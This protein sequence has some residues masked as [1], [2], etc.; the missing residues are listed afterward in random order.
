MID[1]DE[2]FRGTMVLFALKRE[3]SPF[4]RS[5]RDDR[6]IYVGITGI[7][8]DR[9]RAHVESLF[10]KRIRP[11]V[12]VMA[13]YAGALRPGLGVG[14]V[15]VATEVVDA[16]GTSWPT[17]WPMHPARERRKTV[18]F[19]SQK[20][21]GATSQK[22]DLGRQFQADA[23]DME[24][25]AVAEACRQRGIPFGCVRAISDDVQTSLSPRLERMLSAG[26]ISAGRVCWEMVRSPRI[27]GEM[28]RL[29]RNTKRAGKELAVAL[30]QMLVAES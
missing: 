4:L 3:A 20:I 23:V 6:D 25:A 28:V 11:R 21:V 24:S 19:T 18:L 1:I 7:G 10:A 22:R 12:V 2:S 8:L 14:D 27:V 29:G 9:A 15:I 30:R 13:G 5:C 26:R 17:S 16:S